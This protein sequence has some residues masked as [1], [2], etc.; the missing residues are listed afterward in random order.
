MGKPEH[1]REGFSAGDQEDLFAEIFAEASGAAEVDL[2]RDRHGHFWLEREEMRRALE[3]AVT[4]EKILRLEA[5][6]SRRFGPPLSRWPQGKRAAWCVTHDVDYPEA[7]RW[8]EP[9]RIANRLGWR[10]AREAAAM[11]AGRRTHWHFADWISL[12]ERLGIR[13]AFYFCA[14]EGSLTRYAAGTPDPFYDVTSKRFRTLFAELA[15][16]GFEIGLHASYRAFT[17]VERLESERDTLERASGV[18][19]E[20]GRHHYWHL[21]PE[22]PEETLERSARAGLLYDASLAHERYCG[23]RRGISWPYFPFHRRLGRE[24]RSV[25]LPTAWTEDHFFRHRDGHTGD[26]AARL[27]RLADVAER[28]GACLVLNVHQYVYDARLFP[29]RRPLFEE[30][31]RDLVSRSGFWAAT[32][33]Q[34]ARHWTERALA[35]EKASSFW[36]ESVA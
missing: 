14:R 28:Q 30:A 31:A 4:S 3:A 24:V 21:D 22:D 26:L 23:W 33:N 10:G 6:L 7:V 2:P 13:S 11:A 20:G 36:R 35:I 18:R 1:W 25:Q 34:I 17:G 19:I 5:E 9:L 27:R 12:E 32:P 16:R 15:S 29:G 8:I